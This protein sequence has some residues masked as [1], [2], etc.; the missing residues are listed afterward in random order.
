MDNDNMNPQ[1]NS[2]AVFGLAYVGLPLS[3]SYSMKGVK[4]YGIDISEEL[5]NNLKAGITHLYENYKGTPIIEILK[6]CLQNKKFIPSTNADEALR[7]CDKFIITV[8]IPS[9]GG[10]LNFEPLQSACATVSQGL[11]KG[12][13]VVIRS[14]VVPG[15][16]EEKLIP[17]LEKSGLKAG[18]DFHLVYCPERISEGNAFEEFENIPAIISGINPKS[19]DMG[20]EIIKRLSKVEPIPVS[21]I[22]TAETAKVVENIQRDVNIAMVNQFAGFCRRLGIDV[23]EFIQAVNTH[24]R[25]HMLKPGPG[26]GGYCIPNALH[27]LKPKADELDANIDLLSIARNINNYVPLNI[28]EEIRMLIAASGKDT[29]IAKV[30]ILGIAMK[31]NCSDDR[32]SPVIDIICYL[33]GMGI[34]VSVYDNFVAAEYDFKTDSLE[35]CIHQADLILITALQPGMDYNN[36]KL[37]KMLMNENPI[38]FDTRNV[39][40]KTQAKEFGFEVI[41]I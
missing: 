32:Q 20:R 3:L 30:A 14:T 16:T 25:V 40:N 19:V 11:K 27:Y 17:I 6:K 13:T 1:G 39:I 9:N 22:K 31:D 18:D 33:K 15:T 41:S 21:S 7:M 36:Y 34:D 10:H 38:I 4:V 8:G 35:D 28:A 2:L 37:F 24:P 23:F 26:V 12:D 5:V 29:A